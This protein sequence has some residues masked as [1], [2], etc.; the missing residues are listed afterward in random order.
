MKH[1][2]EVIVGN[3]ETM[4][5]DTKRSAKDCFD[6]YVTHSKLG[7]A[8]VANEPVTLLHNG[9]VVEEYIPEEYMNID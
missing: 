8:P 9:D 5:C 4:P 3:M 1:K 7:T 6:Y 2:Y